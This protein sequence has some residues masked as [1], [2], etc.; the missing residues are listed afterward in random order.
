MTKFGTLGMYARCY[1]YIERG[2]VLS[3]SVCYFEHAQTA[4]GLNGAA[5][6]CPTRHYLRSPI[7]MLRV[8]GPPLCS[9][10]LRSSFLPHHFDAC[11]AYVQ[12]GSPF[13][14]TSCVSIKLFL[15]LL[16]IFDFTNRACINRGRTG[17]VCCSAI[18]DQVG[19]CLGCNQVGIK[20]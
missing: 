7:A 12:S 18:A 2:K 6:N 17:V 19:Q 20:D 16:N 1:L 11:L 5:A 9:K 13:W 4:H 3:V 14:S 15:L 10:R 8:K